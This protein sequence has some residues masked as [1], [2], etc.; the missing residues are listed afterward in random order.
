MFYI[1]GVPIKV[2]NVKQGTSKNSS[3][4]IFSYLNLIGWELIYYLLY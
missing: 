4:D 2:V 3:L 1:T